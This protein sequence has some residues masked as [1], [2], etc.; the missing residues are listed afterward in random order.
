[1]GG[2]GHLRRELRGEAARPAQRRV[3]AGLEG[4]PGCRVPGRRRLADHRD[5]RNHQAGRR[6][7][8]AR[9]DADLLPRH[10]VVV[11]DGVRPFVE[12]RLLKYIEAAG[13]RMSAIGLGTWQ[14]GST[15]W[16]YGHRYASEDATVIVHRALE[17]GVNVI[18]TAE[19]YGQHRSER[20]IGEAIRGRRDQV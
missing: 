2:G 5:P 18:D 4:A 12:R 11:A 8:D 1:M 15:E 20:I 19:I 16:G 17:L 7:L 6:A 10:G 9:G 13:A 3:V 14:F